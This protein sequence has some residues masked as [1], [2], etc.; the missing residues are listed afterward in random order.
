MR[1]SH[2]SF[3]SEALMTKMCVWSWIHE[4]WWNDFTHGCGGE[5]TAYTE[6]REAYLQDE[7][8]GPTRGWWFSWRGVGLHSISYKAQNTNLVSQSLTHLGEYTSRICRCSSTSDSTGYLPDV[9]ENQRWKF[10]KRLDERSWYKPKISFQNQFNN[11][12]KIYITFMIS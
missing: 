9:T 3:S 1:Q 12:N 7:T 10:G 4:T 5:N 2:F 11:Q 8:C 6:R